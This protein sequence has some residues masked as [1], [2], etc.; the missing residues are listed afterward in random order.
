MS[1]PPSIEVH[2]LVKRYRGTAHAAV[3]AV[4]FD[5]DDGAFFCLLGPNGAGKSSLVSVLTTVLRPTSGRALVL[6]R[7]VV[8]DQAL[9][10]RQIGVVFQQPALDLNLTAEENIRLHAVLYGLY[11]WRPC[12]RMMPAA[13]RQQVEE[14]ASVVGVTGALGRR[15]R[16]L[17][18]GTRRKLELVRSLMHRPRLLFLDEP[19]VGL[20]PESRR[21]LWTYLDHRRRDEGVT[22]F[23]TTHYLA[24]AE[25]ADMVC[26]LMDGRVVELGAPAALKARRQSA[27]EGSVS[28]V[29]TRPDGLSLE[30]VYL[31]LLDEA[32]RSQ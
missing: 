6:G 4:T 25:T 7:D 14:L 27:H 29:D 2:S 15:V 10:R 30:H 11:G 13:Y 20:D 9:V 22:V 31:E 5:V 16:T 8:R 17:S 32:G 19:T 3:D 21:D 26:V 1:G 24:E 12:H 28:A 18:G 23:L